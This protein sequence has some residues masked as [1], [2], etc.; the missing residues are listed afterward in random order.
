[1]KPKK[2]AKSTPQRSNSYDRLQTPQFALAPVLP[3]LTRHRCIWECAAGD[4][5]LTTALRAAG[6]VVCDTDILTG[7]DFF[8]ADPPSTRIDGIESPVTC[9][10][11]NPPYSCKYPWIT[12]CYELKLPFA[13]LMPLETMGAWSAQRLFRKYGIGVLLLNRRVNF[14]LPTRGW[15]RSS[16]QFPVAWFCHR[17]GF[18]G[19][20]R[21]GVLEKT[22]DRQLTIFDG[23]G[24]PAEI[25]GGGS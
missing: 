3:F 22:D 17:L 9:I 1:M 10:C 8:T 14:H 21:Y 4:G 20:L 25:V 6:H 16:A 7:H 18:D 2:N 23:G 5:H 13:L 12:H 15:E 24:I 19:E 11:T